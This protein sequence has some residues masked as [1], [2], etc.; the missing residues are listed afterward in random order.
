L[1]TGATGFVGTNL[2]KRLLLDG[3]SGSDLVL[4]VSSARGETAA[5]FA[6]QGIRLLEHR[7]YSYAADE[8][9]QLLRDGERMDTVIHLGA[10]TPKGLPEDDAADYGENVRTTQHLVRTLPDK[11]GRFLFGSSVSAYH[12]GDA[13]AD[14]KYGSSKRKCEEWLAGA[15][16]DSDLW[17]LRFGPVYGPGEENYRK[18]VGSFFRQAMNNEDIRLRGDGSSLRRMVYVDDLCG[19]LIRI[20]KLPTGA[21]AAS[22]EQQPDATEPLHGTR[23]HRIDLVNGEAVSIRQIAEYVVSITGSSS[24]IYTETAPAA[25]IPQEITSIPATYRD[26]MRKFYEYLVNKK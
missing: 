9:R 1:I 6:G 20:L 13:S 17:L 14:A 11:P 23:V 24:R 15:L 18:I 5:Q 21:D 7:G 4:L 2:I 16:P 12:E 26:G 8:L 22:G 10:V 3:Y 19:E 25:D